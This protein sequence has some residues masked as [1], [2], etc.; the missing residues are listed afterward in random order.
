MEG[1]LPR[2]GGDGY[3]LTGLILDADPVVQAVMLGLVLASLACWTV[4]F[5]KLVQL[6]RLNRDSRKLESLAKGGN[7][8]GDLFAPYWQRPRSNCR[9]VRARRVT[10]C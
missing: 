6:S 7:I 9:R 10:M 3:S 2:A 8:E 4:I 5:E 1:T